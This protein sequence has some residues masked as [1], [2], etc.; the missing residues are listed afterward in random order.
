VRALAEELGSDSIRFFPGRDWR[1]L[2]VLGEGRGNDVRTTS[3]ALFFGEPLKEHLP[4]RSGGEF[5]RE[6]MERAGAVLVEHEINTVRVD[7]GENP[8]NGV[9]IWGGG[10]P[11]PR[12]KLAGG[13]GV[14]VGAHPSFLGLAH[15][16]GLEVRRAGSGSRAIAEP[17]EVGEQARDALDGTDLVLALLEGGSVLSRAGDAAGKIAY[18]E[19]ADREVVGPIAERLVEAGEGRLLVMATHIAATDLRRD[20]H[21]TMPFLVAGPGIASYGDTGFTERG[22][23]AA[24]LTVERGWE[25]L[26]YAG[27]E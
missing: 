16:V 27:R 8:A 26:E 12:A 5:L 4:R 13:N 3:P 11:R 22:A 20:L 24:D 10:R 19:E 2:L 6:L 7:L 14:A 15:G 21:G 23:E 9:W 1:S 25:L 17:A 18:L